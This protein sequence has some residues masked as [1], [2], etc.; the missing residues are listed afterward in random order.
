MSFTKVG[1]SQ[2]L[3]VKRLRKE[4][5]R[6]S[7]LDV[8]WWQV[9]LLSSC[10]SEC[11]TLGERL[12]CV[13]SWSEDLKDGQS[14]GYNSRP[15][16][17]IRYLEICDSPRKSWSCN[18]GLHHLFLK[19]RICDF[20]HDQHSKYASVVSMAFNSTSC[21]SQSTSHNRFLIKGPRT[22]SQVTRRRSCS[23]SNLSLTSHMENQNSDYSL[24]I[25]VGCTCMV[26]TDRKKN[27][28][29]VVCS[30]ILYAVYR[31]HELR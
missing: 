22:I 3:I 31:M 9:L 17:F 29:R 16:Y 30:R 27:D 1:A 20:S 26:R 13:R 2:K 10:Y 14:S 24:R 4:T 15:V 6:C 12:I 18:G 19:Y 11:R 8:C 5:T 7:D 28:E 21:V 25:R 23:W